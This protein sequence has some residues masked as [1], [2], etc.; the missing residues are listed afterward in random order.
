MSCQ[1]VIV[2]VRV[3]E[4]AWFLNYRYPTKREA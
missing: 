1:S 2:R 4:S 3:D